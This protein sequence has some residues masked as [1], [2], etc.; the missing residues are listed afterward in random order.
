MRNDS[1]K[2]YVEAKEVNYESGDLLILYTDGIIEAKNKTGDEYGYDRLCHSIE[3]NA[4]LDPSRIKDKVIEDL[5]G[6]TDGIAL[7]DDYTLLIIKFL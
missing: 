7:D 5:S 4:S 1:F 2:N 3:L 6:F